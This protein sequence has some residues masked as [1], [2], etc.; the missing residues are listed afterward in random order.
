MDSRT[1]PDDCAWEVGSARSGP[2]GVRGLIV[3][4][5][6]G[7]TKYAHSQRFRP[8]CRGFHPPGAHGVTCS[9]KNVRVVQRKSAR[10]EF[11]LRTP[12]ATSLSVTARRR[13]G[14]LPP[15]PQPPPPPPPHDEPPPQE[16]PPEPSLPES[17]PDHQ[18]PEPPPPSAEAP[19][20]VVRRLPD[21]RLRRSTPAGDPQTGHQRSD[22]DHGN[23]HRDED[24]HA[25]HPPFFS[26]EARSPVASPL[27][28]DRGIPPA[29]SR[30]SGLEQLQSFGPGW[31]P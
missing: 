14:Q 4:F 8:T 2:T 7:I 23:Q 22:D 1:P 11:T 21:A 17:P 16:C 3:L 25:P 20:D 6:E 12:G 18:P 9:I 15:P 26:P 27:L 24:V 29:S 5:N 10:R 31:R 19:L 13:P 28:C 30:Q